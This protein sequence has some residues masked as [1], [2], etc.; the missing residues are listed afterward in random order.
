MLLKTNPE[1]VKPQIMNGSI[2]KPKKIEEKNPQKQSNETGE[3]ETKENP[4]HIFTWNE[5]K[6]GNF[7]REE[8]NARSEKGRKLEIGDEWVWIVKPVT[9]S[10]L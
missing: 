4:A 10:F 8:I 1:K 6:V 2:E 9:L 7:W 5:L 3:G